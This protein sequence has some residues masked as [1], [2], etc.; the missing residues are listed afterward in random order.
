MMKAAIVEKP[1]VLTVREVPTPAPGDYEV[2]CALLYGA[3]CTGTDQHIIHGRMPW[4]ID[5]PAILG[6]ES[7]G[8]VIAVGPRVRNF[9]EGDLITRVGAP[10]APD[11]S[12]GLAWGGFA[13]YGI[14]RDH[15]AMREDG[16]PQEEWNNYRVNQVVPPDIDAA[17][18]TLIITWRETLSYVSRMGVGPGTAVLIIGSGGNGLAFAAHVK[19]LGAGPILMTGSPAR[20]AAARRVGVTRYYDYHSP[21]LAEQMADDV[22]EGV[23]FVIDAVG[24]SGQIDRALPLLKPG[25]CLGLYGIDDFDGAPVNLRRA[26]GGFTYFSGGCDEEESHERVVAFMQEGMLDAS[27][28]LDGECVFPLGEIGAA[29]DA[30]RER[31]A[32]KALVALSPERHSEA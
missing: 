7:V 4:P 17:A 25:G 26:R 18:A 9:R 5:Y 23:D 28:W 11:G 31:K 10:P 2:L 13:E 21:S 22:G 14:A 19:I 27:I 15:R 3:T 30:L 29:F 1:G 16:R 32:V 20:E 8:R 6:H 12:Y 24:R